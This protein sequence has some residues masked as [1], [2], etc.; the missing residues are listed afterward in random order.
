MNKINDALA[1]SKEGRVPSKKIAIEVSDD[2]EQMEAMDHDG[3]NG[4][5][6][7]DGG[8]NT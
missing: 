4:D 7:G 8:N 2:D 1:A 5:D 6:G 3:H